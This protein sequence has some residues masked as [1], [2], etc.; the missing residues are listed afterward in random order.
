MQ[1]TFHPQGA[2]LVESAFSYISVSKFFYVFF[3]SFQSEIR[4]KLC[5]PFPCEN[6]EFHLFTHDFPFGNH[7]IDKTFFIV[8]PNSATQFGWQI[9][10]FDKLC[11][12]WF[13]PLFHGF[14]H[15]SWF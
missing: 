12:I 2:P 8:N 10:Y 6:M 11:P 15:F 9:Q 5:C 13:L 14:Y 3:Q 7:F 4:L 1:N